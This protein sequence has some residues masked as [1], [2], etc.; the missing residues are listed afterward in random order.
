MLAGLFGMVI[1][2]FPGGIIIWLAALIYGLL[3][4]FGTTGT[5]IMVGLT[6]LMIATSVADDILMGAKARK[7]GASWR[8]IIFASI[9]GVLGTIFFPPFGGLVGAPLIFFLNEY[10]RLKDSSEA[11]RLTKG[12]M[13]GCGWAF[14]VRF[15]LGMVMIGLWGIW[16]WSNSG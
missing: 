7:E 2:I 13:V 14:I 12:L 16:V 11:M 15:G 6:L 8:G 9:A 4:G 10:I 3:F 1:P 5:W